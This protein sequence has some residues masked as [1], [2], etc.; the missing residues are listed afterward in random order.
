MQFVHR[1]MNRSTLFFTDLKRPTLAK[2]SEPFSDGDSVDIIQRSKAKETH[3][4]HDDDRDQSQLSRTPIK[5]KDYAYT[6]DTEKIVLSDKTQ[7]ETP[8]QCIYAFQYAEMT[9]KLPKLMSILDVLNELKEWATVTVK[10]KITRKTET[11]TVGKNK[12]SLC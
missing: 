12:L 9:T 11:R 6:E 2:F 1:N 4:R 7:V 5:I 10:G 8:Q 3:E